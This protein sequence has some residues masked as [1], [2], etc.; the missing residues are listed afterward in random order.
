M[1]NYAQRECILALENDGTRTDLTKIMR[2]LGTLL[3]LNQIGAWDLDLIDQTANR[4]LEHDRIFGY[5]SLLPNW[6]YEMFLGHVLPED[7]T[8]V[9]FLFQTAV[10]EQKEW[11]FECRIRRVDGVVRWIFASGSPQFD[12]AGV[13]RRL[14]GIVQDISERK[15]AEQRQLAL[16]KKLTSIN[17]ELNNFTFVASHDLKSPLRGI[18]QLASWIT[19]DLGDNISSETQGH[20]RLMRNRIKRMEMLLDDLLHYARIGQAD[21]EVVTVNTD[22]LVRD[23][24][25]LVATSKKI[26]LHIPQKLPTLLTQ[27]APL[28]L[29]LR[30]LISNAIKHHDKPECT[31]TISTHATTDGVEFSVA[32][33]GPGIHPEYQQRVFAIFQ[34]LKTRDQAEG[35]GMGLALVKK[36][37]ELMGGTITLES[38]GKCGC[39]FRFSWPTK[40]HREDAL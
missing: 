21:N 25:D 26:N 32:D 24:V 6:T 39:T 19:E 11:Q 30:N 14:A 29:V 34:T 31:I 17:E 23:I 40:Q 13:A 10:A 4:T 18:D 20:L 1:S 35:S 5:T 27:K 15:E 9:D 33:D 28:D 38:D 7:R 8:S 36:T 22:E 16:L 3:E 2:S 37:I 12:E